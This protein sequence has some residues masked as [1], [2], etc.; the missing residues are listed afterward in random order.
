MAKEQQMSFLSRNGKTMIHAV[1]WLPENGDYQAILQITHGMIEYIERYRSF[2]EYLT[3][4]GFMVVGHDH[5]EHGASINKEEAWG[6]FGEHPSDIL[7]EDMHQLRTIIQI[8]NPG[9]PYFMLGFSMGSYMLRK[10]IC[11]HNENLAGA[12]IMGTGCMPDGSMRMGMLLCKVMAAFRG[13]DYRSKF[14]QSL[15]YDKPY[16]KY[17]LYGKDYTNSWLTKDVEI[18]KNYYADPRC[19]FMFTLNA[20]YGLMEAVYY[21]NQRNNIEKVPKD[22][23]IILMSGDQDPVGNLGKGVRKV[24]DKF[25]D[26]GIKDLTCKLYENDRHEILNE[27]DRKQV[28]LDV[29]AWINAHMPEKA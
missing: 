9:I 17:D 16:K 25:K 6:Y 7:T 26:A 27:L 23:P 24:Y 15:S 2:A 13:W 19:T 3:E 1:K 29:Y 8:E 4:H 14:M 12:I 10:Y 11:I 28:F 22:L 20:Y 21:D 5:L 18:V